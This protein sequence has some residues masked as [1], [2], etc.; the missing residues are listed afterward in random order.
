[1]PDKEKDEELAADASASSSEKKEKKKKEK[2]VVEEVAEKKTHLG[3]TATIKRLM[4]D[5]V[6]DVFL[7]SKEGR[8]YVEDTS[9]SNLKLVVG[10]AGVGASL[11]SHV[12]PAPFPKN[13]WVLLLCCAFY[14]GMSGILQLLLSF[15]E[16]ESILVVRGKTDAD[17]N[18]KATPGI[19]ISSHFP[20]FQEVYTLGVTPVPGSALA[21]HKCP[22]FRPDVSG[23]NTAAHCLQRSWSVE[24]FFDEEGV[25]AESDFWKAVEEF[26]L[27]YERMIASDPDGSKKAN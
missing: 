18:K 5:A 8:G 7:D 26:V 21:L 20:R 15:V 19:N 12:Y 13:W 1:M 10:F 22:R 3:D 14:F 9:M 4:D 2:K 24:K 6:I 27:E 16:L 23:G 17:G 25:F 11:L